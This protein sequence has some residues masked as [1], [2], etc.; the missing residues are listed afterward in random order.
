MTGKSQED[1]QGFLLE[2]GVEEL[3]A[4]AARAALLQAKDLVAGIFSERRLQFQPQQINIWVTPRRIAIFLEELG[5]RQA[6]EEF[7]ERGPRADAAF[8][9]K[10]KPTKAAAGFARAKGVKVEDLETRQDGGQQFVFA[11]HRNSSTGN[12]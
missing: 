6:A 8:N 10:G 11:V 9:E 5:A 3:P 7:A 1:A 4:S 2:I 12:C